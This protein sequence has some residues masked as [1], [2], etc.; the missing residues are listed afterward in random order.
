MAMPTP[1]ATQI[2]VAAILDELLQRARTVKPSTSIDPQL[3]VSELASGDEP[4][5]GGFTVEKDI[6]STALESAARRIFYA[7]IVRQSQPFL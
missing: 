1:N 4:L 7:N 5:F 6:L 2:N 3:Q